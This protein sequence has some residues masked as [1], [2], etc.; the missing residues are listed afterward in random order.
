MLSGEIV[1]KMQ[2]GFYG[3]IVFAWCWQKISLSVCVMVVKDILVFQSTC[4]HR[5]LCLGLCESIWWSGSLLHFNYN[6][7]RW[8]KSPTEAM[9]FIIYYKKKHFFLPICLYFCHSFLFIST[10]LFCVPKLCNIQHW[11]EN[12]FFFFNSWNEFLIF[13]K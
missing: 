3:N 7:D 10:P 9:I 4:A 13:Y 5:F 1:E 8:R 12:H 2:T 6:A 11:V